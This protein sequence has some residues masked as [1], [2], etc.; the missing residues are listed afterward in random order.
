MG[1]V[2]SVEVTF[3]GGEGECGD[4]RSMEVMCMR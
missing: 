3:G 2:E 4:R 1:I